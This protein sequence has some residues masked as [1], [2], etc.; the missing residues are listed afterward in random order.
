MTHKIF[1]L[2]DA[3]EERLLREW[4]RDH[5]RELV[6]AR[7]K[8]LHWERKVAKYGGEIHR[9]TLARMDAELK[10]LEGM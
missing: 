10:R 6:A 8:V 3:R 9:E 4:K 2:H 5:Q 1:T 7:K